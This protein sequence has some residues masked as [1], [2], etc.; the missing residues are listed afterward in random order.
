M[1]KLIITACAYTLLRLAAV[2]IC[3]EPHTYINICPQI[4]QLTLATTSIY[5]PLAYQSYEDHTTYL[6]FLHWT[7]CR[8]NR[9]RHTV[10]VLYARKQAQHLSPVEVHYCVVTKAGKFSVLQTQYSL[11]TG[12]R[13]FDLWI[14]ISCN[15]K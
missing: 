3:I 14:F 9:A 2:H 13:C 12:A 10:T 11:Q 4:S 5:K 7:L 1:G 8:D 15:T 6:Y